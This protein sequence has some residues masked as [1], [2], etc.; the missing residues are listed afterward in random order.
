MEILLE[1]VSLTTS[2]IRSEVVRAIVDR[3]STSRNLER[4]PRFLINDVL[5]YW[6]T[7]TVDFQAKRDSSHD[8]HKMIL[9]YLKLRITRKILLA[10]SVLPLI[11]FTPACPTRDHY[12]DELEKLFD[13]PALCRLIGTVDRLGDSSLTEHARTVCRVLDGFLAASSSKAQRERFDK[14]AWDD[15]G[16]HAEFV[17]LSDS[18][19][20][21]DAALA[22]IFTSS[23][24]LEATK[25]YMLF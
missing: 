22:A 25:S 11:T 4:P 14:I 6:R 12:V 8:Q 23:N 2:G 9:R 18:A 16:N 20:R 1:S 3:Y 13:Q 17:D 15:R 24:V 19:D 5:R 21:L 10:S 7:I